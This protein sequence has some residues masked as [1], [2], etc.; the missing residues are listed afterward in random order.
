MGYK[1][2]I[3]ASQISSFTIGHSWRFRPVLV[4]ANSNPQHHSRFST[5]T[6]GSLCI[7]RE[8][9]GYGGGP[10]KCCFRL[11]L[12]YKTSLLLNAPQVL[13]YLPLPSPYLWF[14]GHLPLNAKNAFP[15]WLFGN[16]EFWN[17]IKT[18]KKSE[19]HQKIALLPLL[20]LNPIDSKFFFIQTSRTKTRM[21]IKIQS[22]FNRPSHTNK[23]EKQNKKRWIVVLFQI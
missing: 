12:R 15:F 9:C 7:N 5:A 6:C 13:D 14:V 1:R 19:L 17:N 3:I 16:N 8:C 22:L 23:I 20:H 4:A 11:Q 10:S 18:S 21:G 2:K